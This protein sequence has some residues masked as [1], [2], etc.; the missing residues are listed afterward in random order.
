MQS[1]LHLTRPLLCPMY[2][3]D[4]HVRSISKHYGVEEEVSKWRPRSELGDAIVLCL[5]IFDAV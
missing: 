1:T 2:C 3:L 5:T 4:T